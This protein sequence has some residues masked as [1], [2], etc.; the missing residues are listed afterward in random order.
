MA[1]SADIYQLKVTLEG[2]KPPIWRR[3]QVDKNSKLSELHEV[4]QRSM[5]WEN[6]HLHQFEAGRTLYGV[7]HPDYGFDMKDEA[8]VK[9]SQI[10]A[11]EKDK[12]SYEYDFGD[13]WLHK[14]VLEKILPRCSDTHYPVCTKGK[15]ACPP[16]DCGGIW[17]YYELLDAVQDPD[18][19]DHEDMLEWLGEFDPTVFDRED[20][21]EALQTL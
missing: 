5:G 11:H 20:V 15:G 1:D 18:H 16:E 9:L 21:N 2:S 13:G 19:P 12:F 4:L 8:E 6:Y 14:I 10:V 3:L 7:P 17:G